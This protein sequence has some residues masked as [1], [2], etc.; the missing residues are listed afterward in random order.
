MTSFLDKISRIYVNI[1]ILAYALLYYVLSQTSLNI[2]HDVTLFLEIGNRLLDGQT[3]YVDFFEFNFP[4]IQYFSAIFPLISRMTGVNVIIVTQIVTW[5]IIGWSALSLY[6]FTKKIT[7]DYHLPYV[8]PTALIVYSTA[9]Q[10]PPF[11][12]PLF[13][14]REHIFILLFLP[15]MLIR[16]WQ[17]GEE[18]EKTGKGYRFLYGFI[19]AIGVAIKPYF[20]IVPIL[21]ELYGLTVH[22]DFKRFKRAE[23]YGFVVFAVLHLIYFLVFTDIRAGL[24]D[25]LALAQFGYGNYIRINHPFPLFN[26]LVYDDIRNTFFVLM[27]LNLIRYIS[28]KTRVLIVA[29]SVFVFSGILIFSMQV[30]FRYHMLVFQSGTWILILYGLARFMHPPH[31]DENGRYDLLRNPIIYIIL[32]VSLY[33]MMIYFNIYRP[34]NQ[35]FNTLTDYQEFI[36]DHTAEDEAIL[37]IDYQFAGL[38]YPDL[39]QINRRNISPYPIDA[40]YSLGWENADTVE[41]RI[42]TNSPHVDTWLERLRAFIEESDTRLIVASEEMNRYLVGIGFIDDTILPRYDRIEEN[43]TYVAYQLMP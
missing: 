32:L 36:L 6:V 12:E 15:F 43:D 19:G 5:L 23:I 18:T 35:S 1:P 20:A 8:L 9:L 11:D 25:M 40:P 17:W 37:V 21:I 22:R 26:W 34:S 30:G 28:D 10:V 33:L 41:E 3:P 13:A 2:N 16:V 24:S 31:A 7:N 38:N 29:L 14:Q 42:V 27:L 4:V 39:Y